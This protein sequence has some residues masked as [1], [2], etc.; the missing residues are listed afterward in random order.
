M[1]CFY[2]CHVMLSSGIQK[3]NIVEIIE[4]VNKAYLEILDARERSPFCSIENIIRQY[5]NL[6]AKSNTKIRWCIPEHNIVLIREYIDFDIKW[7]DKLL[8]IHKDIQIEHANVAKVY[9]SFKEMIQIRGKM[10]G[11]LWIVTDY[12]EE[13]VNYDNKLTEK[14]I[15]HICRDYING[16]Y[17]IKNNAKLM[18][19]ICKKKILGTRRQPKNLQEYCELSLNF[20]KGLISVQKK[21]PERFFFFDVI[22]IENKSKIEKK[23]LHGQESLS[24]YIKCL[25]NE[26]SD[27]YAKARVEDVKKP[28]AVKE[29]EFDLSMSV[30][31]SSD[32]HNKYPY[33]LVIEVAQ[34]DKKITWQSRLENDI[35]IK[36]IEYVDTI[37]KITKLLT[38]ETTEI[39]Y[40]IDDG[41][42]KK[43]N[44]VTNALDKN[45]KQA[46]L[47]PLKTILNL[48]RINFADN[49]DPILNEAKLVFV[50]YKFPYVDYYKDPYLIY[51]HE[52][53]QRKIAKYTTDEFIHP[54]YICYVNVGLM[55]VYL[56]DP[57]IEPNKYE[58]Y[59]YFYTRI[60]LIDKIYAEK[61][62]DIPAQMKDFI[63]ML[64]NYNV[65]AFDLLNSKFLT[66]DIISN[67]FSGMLQK[68]HDKVKSILH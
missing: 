45:G 31:K 20:L 43:C 17:Y 11:A 32:N 19:L 66:E 8:G 62:K 60:E 6:I 67:K 24:S 68:V 51:E 27:I 16:I 56:Y 65:N 55:A 21:H 53:L 33:N 34:N 22:N 39:R 63:S 47:S 38:S 10:E 3:I 59:K 58:I 44:N 2:I 42:A 25:E 5:P 57:S 1:I 48:H 4:K 28:F 64:L 41:V 14:Q 7:K 54:S 61:K 50:L 37:K 12:L 26:L 40:D 9:L 15:K 49:L 52:F 23:I 35:V 46:K 13:K 36:P 29:A 18:P 30:L